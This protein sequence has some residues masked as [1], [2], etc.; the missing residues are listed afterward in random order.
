ML[1]FTHY[2][3]NLSFSHEFTSFALLQVQILIS[4]RTIN[5][6]LR[7]L[8]VVERRFNNQFPLCF[9]YCRGLFVLFL[10]MNLT[11]LKSSRKI[12]RLFTDNLNQLE[13]NTEK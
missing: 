5:L 13:M 2:N 12:T 6:I 1:I 7:C 4:K 10:L 3:I 9:C 8:V 11:V